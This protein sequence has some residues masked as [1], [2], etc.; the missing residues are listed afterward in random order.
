MQFDRADFIIA[1]NTTQRSDGVPPWSKGGSPALIVDV[2]IECPC[3]S[4]DDKT[5]QLI[6]EIEEFEVRCVG[7]T[8]QHASTILNMQK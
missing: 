3:S 4:S 2:L 6:I 7:L 1:S 8:Y 5:A